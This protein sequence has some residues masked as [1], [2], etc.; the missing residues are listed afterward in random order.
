M[1]F[2]ALEAPGNDRDVLITGSLF[3]D[4]LPLP[5][6]CRQHGEPLGAAVLQGEVNVLQREPE[7][8]LG[9]IVLALDAPELPDL[10]RRDER[11]AL[12]RLDDAMCVEPESV[13]QCHRVRYPFG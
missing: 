10:P 1:S 4:L 12:E 8:K 13:C 5:G 7:R 3:D 9:G 11:T 2:S 6:K